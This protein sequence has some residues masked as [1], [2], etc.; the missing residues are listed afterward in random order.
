MHFKIKTK[1]HGK[2]S[3]HVKISESLSSNDQKT[4][5]LPKPHFYK[6]LSVVKRFFRELKKKNFTE[7]SERING[8]FYIVYKIPREI[9][10]SS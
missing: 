3:K 8:V 1:A 9:F 2:S 10:E 5:P 4:L 6:V 7:N